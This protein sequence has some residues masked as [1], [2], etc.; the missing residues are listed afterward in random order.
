MES[1][2]R[3]IFKTKNSG[4]GARGTLARVL[5]EIVVSVRLYQRSMGS[6]PIGNSYHADPP[7]QAIYMGGFLN[8]EFI[9][10]QLAINFIA[11]SAVSES[12]A[13]DLAEVAF[14]FFEGW[15][16]FSFPEDTK[17]M[18]NSDFDPRG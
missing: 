10:Q 12:D 9:K 2:P 5:Q 7:V 18:A 16:I 3:P 4:W 6:A 17:T 15:G 14:E 1:G 8:S 13:Q 11:R